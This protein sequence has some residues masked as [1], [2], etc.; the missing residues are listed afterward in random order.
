[1]DRAV[2]DTPARDYAWLE[3]ARRASRFKAALA[4][5]RTIAG[6]E[7]RF[8]AEQL[9]A[10]AAVFTDAAQAAGDGEPDAAAVA[11]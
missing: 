11:S 4:R 8:T 9:T 5:V 7:P 3:D 1:V 2:Q 10:L 6:T